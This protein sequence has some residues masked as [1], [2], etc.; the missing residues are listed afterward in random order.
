MD[1]N[2]TLLSDSE[3][4]ITQ[5][6]R[7]NTH[8]TV[9]T[10]INNTNKFLKIAHLN[11][12]GLKRR[13]Q[14]PDF[15]DLV[16]Q[17]D[18][19]LVTETKLD[20]T[21]VIDIK[22][23]QFINIPRE[24]KY[25][26]KSGG[27]G[28]FIKDN[29]PYHT[30]TIKTNT[31]YIFWVKLK[32]HHTSR[33]FII[34]TIYIP[35]EQSR[36]YSDDE[37]DMLESCITDMCSKHEHVFLFGDYNAQTG[38]SLEYIETDDFLSDLFDYDQETINYLNQK[39]NMLKYN[40]PLK[41]KSMDK[42]KNNHGFRIIELC[43]NNNL[44]IGNGRL[45]R[46]KDIGRMTFRNVSVI[47][48]LIL[49]I[50]GYS[51]VNDFIISE[52]NNIHSDGHALLECT[53][54]IP[55]TNKIVNKKPKPQKP[56]WNE[57][58][59][60]EFIENISEEQ[61]NHLISTIQNSNAPSN[62]DSSNH[63]KIDWFTT[64]IEK[65][66][67]TSAEKTFSTPKHRFHTN[68]KKHKPWFGL[69]CHKARKQYNK[70]HRK[71]S[72]HP[73][74]ENKIN[75]KNTCK[76]YKA[77]MNKY[78]NRYNKNNEDK[79]RT[80]HSKQPKDYWKYLN[81]LNKINTKNENTPTVESLYQHFK[82]AS[83]NEE[84]EM[85]DSDILS[86][87]DVSDDSNCLNSSIT[88]NEIEKCIN[89]LNNNKAAGIDNIINEYI[90]TTK[91]KMLPL[92][93]SLFNLIIDT[94]YIPQKWSEGLIVPI[95]KN[96]GDSQDPINYRPITLLSC[97][98]KLFTSVLN[99][100][101]TKYL[102]ENNILKENQAGFRQ[103]Y[104]T[105][106]HIFALNSIIEILRHSKKKIY[107]TFI[108]FSKA[109]DSVWHIGLW[110][111][112]L[113]Y[114]INGKFFRVIK[115]IYNN[116]KSCI[117]INNNNSNFF[118]SNCG[119]RQ[120]ENLSPILFSLFLNDL[121]NHLIKAGNHGIKFTDPSDELNTLFQI[122]TL[123]YADDTIIMSDNPQK[124]QE[125]LKAFELY[126]KQWKLNINTDKTK[127]VIFGSK[128]KN[129]YQFK[130]ENKIIEIVTTYKYLGAYFTRSG[131]FLSTRKHLAQQARK[132]LFLLYKR[133]NNLN[134]PFDLIFKLFDHTIAPILTYASETWGYEN[135]LILERIHCEFIRKV[136]KLRK[137]T[138][139][140][141]LYAESGRYPLEITIQTRM[142]G[143]WARLITGNHNKISYQLYSYMLKTDNLNSKWIS[144]IQ[145]TLNQC[146]MH[147]VWLNQFA[148]I[149]KHLK[150]QV[151]QRLLDQYRQ[152]W[153]TQ[154]QESHKG[155]YY[156]IY[157]ENIAL[158]EHLLK[159]NKSE[160]ITFVKFRA[161]NHFLPVEQGRWQ[162][163]EYAD[164]KC[165]LCNSV[166]VADELHYILICP[167]FENERKTY[168]KKYFYTRPNL[169]K[170]KTLMRSTSTIKL[171]KLCAFIKIIL[172]SKEIKQQR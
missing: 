165:H 41:R 8:D 141:I 128:N 4:N 153:N 163:I 118:H 39:P 43:K 83:N 151:K 172:N 145:A 69:D 112:L 107:C 80:M 45:G 61:I 36:F 108:D 32:Q 135:I 85:D 133:I 130:L 124:L 44:V 140:Y 120:G 62:S 16:N 64:E 86:K 72:K 81:K 166:D 48:Y 119:I 88:P 42:K 167:K 122:I 89:K 127:V 142:I 105:I 17:F 59:Q 79:L 131:S 154:L 19:F 109:F 49:S 168:I 35:P 116:I 139:K 113:S 58:K 27:I 144:K 30:E 132:A 159:L 71:Y 97:I 13:C 99:C 123:L 65:L 162:N 149:N 74:M 158:E 98:S 57:S 129:E 150:Q 21:D 46:D 54:N 23:Y 147:D 103:D 33:E 50:P 67:I 138:P 37:Y 77:T 10:T 171:R 91:T 68:H 78:I 14:Y 1:N 160:H 101:I 66:L 146:G 169:M 2:S 100:R 92:Y 6:E 87:I 56:K 3:V 114:D 15:E 110:Q 63:S 9:F 18:I 155:R 12:C 31:D 117:T 20:C 22:G 47:D 60:T 170:F 93:V 157:K 156:S 24:K 104:S 90:K 11:V 34:G 125:S 73:S 52:T 136:L 75:Y 53:L 7:G 26:R 152:T 70:A 164:R 84:H 95:Y 29:L 5:S 137:S 82:K 25:E 161:S 126:C 134:L 94:G 143:Y 55:N 106:D 51:M 76:H 38:E 115:N 111:K 102:D 28:A 40:I 148:Y 96:K 121:E